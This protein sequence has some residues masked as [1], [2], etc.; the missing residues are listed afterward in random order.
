[1]SGRPVQGPKG[2]IQRLGAGG[3]KAPATNEE[4]LRAPGATTGVV[5]APEHPDPSWPTPSYVERLER[6]I[7]RLQGEHPELYE[8]WRAYMQD[9]LATEPL[10]YAPDPDRAR[11]AHQRKREL[12]TE[13][14]R[15]HRGELAPDPDD[16]PES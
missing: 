10:G 11:R 2:L 15:K 14:A 16:P 13:F 6:R 1:M 8:D 5:I 4:P 9:D 7:F 12:L 3:A